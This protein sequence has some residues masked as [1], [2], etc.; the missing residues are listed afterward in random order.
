[1]DGGTGDVLV[2]A[3]TAEQVA[4]AA[5]TISALCEA[6]EV[7]RSAGCLKEAQ[8]CRYRKSRTLKRMRE[9]AR[10][11]EGLLQALT[12]QRAHEVAEQAKRR[13]Q[14]AEANAMTATL[15]GIKK[16]IAA[17]DVKRKAIMEKTQGVEAAVAA[18]H[19]LAQFSIDDLK[20]KTQRISALE[21]L[22]RL[23]GAL[24]PQ[25]VLEWEWFK[26][27][28]DEDMRK[29]HGG[30]WPERFAGWLQNVANEMASGDG[31]AFSKFVHNESLRLL[32]NENGE[33]QLALVLPMEAAV[34]V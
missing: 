15:R 30:G 23:K 2:D 3:E 5:E 16:Q 28:W 29:T 20:K 14:I 31:E 33:P 12:A 19:H 17:A 11:D 8:D 13:R 10:E 18:K 7:L 25:Q 26:N 4:V 21:K 32:D 24:S 6:E 9:L 1:M 34:A 22:K 27:A